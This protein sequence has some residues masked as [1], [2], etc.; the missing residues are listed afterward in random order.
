[1]QKI[2]S[3]SLKNPITLIL[4]AYSLIRILYCLV[5]VF[6]FDEAWFGGYMREVFEK[7]TIEYLG[8]SPL[9]WIFGHFIL[10]QF[11][12]LVVLRLI[13]IYCYFKNLIYLE[14]DIN[15]FNSF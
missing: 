2:K 3:H 5:P 11:N 13:F 9:F 8:Y 6:N 7:Q 10:N 1:M 12:N 15:Y 14:F 4:I